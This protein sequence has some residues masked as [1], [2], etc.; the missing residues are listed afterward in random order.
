MASA[1]AIMA[2][3][4]QSEERLQHES[5]ALPEEIDI[6]VKYLGV[7]EPKELAS[8][9]KLNRKDRYYQALLMSNEFLY[10]D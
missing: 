3:P 5:V 10:V 6:G 4:K 7:N 8:Q 9:N 2:D 1:A